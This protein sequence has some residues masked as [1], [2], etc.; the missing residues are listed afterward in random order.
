MHEDIKLRAGNYKQLI[1]NYKESLCNIGAC[2]IQV[3]AYN[4]MPVLDWVRT[5]QN[6]LNEDGTRSLLYNHIAFAY[7]DV[8]LLNRPD[9]KEDYD[10]ALV[11]KAEDYGNQ[12]SDEAKQLLFKNV[13]LGLPGSKVNFTADQLLRQLLDYMDIDD[14]KLR[15]HLI[16]FLEEVAPIAQ[17]QGICL[18]IH[19]DD[20][21]FSV[22]GLP[23]VVSTKADLTAIFNA[24]P[25]YSNG[26]CF[27]TGSLAAHSTN[28]LVDM[29]DSFADRIHF[30]HLRNVIR[31][32]EHIFR[33]APHLAGD[34][35]M[36]AVVKKTLQLMQK[37]K[38]SIPMRPDHG[39]L[40]TIEAHKQFY[41]GYSLMGRLK[42]LSELRGLEQGVSYEM[43]NRV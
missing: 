23:R 29:I 10:E 3:V 33:E 25:I 41:P 22:L 21:P 38:K 1:A 14:H 30:L 15:Q 24:V 19:P 40:H 5:E 28:N 32:N 9:A 18:A 16:L 27:C 31:E 20:P 42:G 26:L 37:R 11:Q 13:L 34:V 2:G 6:H 12:L 43:K 8:F 39:F 35:N 4:F 7:F 36:E 17:L